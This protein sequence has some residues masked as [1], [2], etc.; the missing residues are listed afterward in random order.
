MVT[1]LRAFPPGLEELFLRGNHKRDHLHA[2]EH[3]LTERWEGNLLDATTE[4]HDHKNLRLCVMLSEVG[5]D[6][7]FSRCHSRIVRDK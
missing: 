2:V 7:I 6:G 1:P 4:L 5:R 3:V